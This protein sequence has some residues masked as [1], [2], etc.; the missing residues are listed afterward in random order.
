MQAVFRQCVFHAR[1]EHGI[2]EGHRKLY[3]WR[4][5]GHKLKVGGICSSRH[6]MQSGM[7]L[8]SRRYKVSSSG[9][10]LI[11]ASLMTDQ[12]VIDDVVNDSLLIGLGACLRDFNS[13][14]IG[15]GAWLWSLLPPPLI[16]K[17]Y[18]EPSGTSLQARAKPNRRRHA[19]SQ[20][21]TWW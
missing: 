21:A 17:N 14:L 7:V 6:I 10:V 4:N 2:F 16:P 5:F 13:L 15:Q 18:L 20:W 9:P 8:L 1:V 3:G 12:H 11:L 19:N